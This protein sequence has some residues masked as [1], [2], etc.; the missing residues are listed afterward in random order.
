MIANSA[1]T[2]ELDAPKSQELGKITVDIQ[3]QYDELA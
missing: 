3:A 1:L 2:V